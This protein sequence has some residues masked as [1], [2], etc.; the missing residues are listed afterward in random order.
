MHHTLSTSSIE[1][2]PVPM[3]NRNIDVD[4]PPPPYTPGKIQGKSE[5]S[6]SPHSIMGD[7]PD[8]DRPQRIVM[9]KFDLYE[10]KTC[11]YV[12]GS[13]Q[14]DTGFRVLRIDRTSPAEPV[15]SADEPVY[16][17]QE[18]IE[19]LK[20]IEH[21]NVSSGKL[22]F[23]SIFGVIGFIKFTE[24]YY[25]YLITKRSVVALIGGHYVYHIDDTKLLPIGQP[26]KHGKNSDEMRYTGI[27]HN[28]DL[29]K[30]FYFSYTYDITNTLQRNM[31][32]PP[33]A[34]DDTGG[35]VG[36]TYNGMF[37]W[38]HYLLENG[39]KDLTGKSDWILPIIYGFVDQAKISVFGRNVFVTLIARRS[40][41]FA[42]ARFL[43]RGV[44]DKGYVANDVELEQIVAEMSTTSFHTPDRLFGNP[45][46]TSHVQHRGSIPLFWSQ[47]SQ[48]NSG[49][50]PKPPITLNVVDPFYTAAG[51]HFDD[52]FKR[53][54]APCIILNL[55]KQ[56][57]K[58]P[59]ESILLGEFSAAINY[60][61]QFLPEEK[62][63]QHIA[64][65]MSRASKSPDQDV[66]G[67]LEKIAEKSLA[68]T[69]FFHSGPEPYVNVMRR[70]QA[71]KDEK[72][73][74][75]IIARQN[76]VVRTN[77]IDCLDR[78]NA[79]QF[80]VGKCALGQQLYALGIIDHPN[81]EFDS[82]VVNILTEMYHDHGDTIALQYGGSHL[83][84]TME[85]YRKINQW[86]SHSR[87]MIESIRRYINNSFG[88]PEKQEAINLFL[89]NYVVNDNQLSLWDLTTDHFLHNQRLKAR[90]N[91]QNWWTADAIVR[92]EEKEPD[93]SVFT[94]SLHQPHGLYDEADLYTG[95][96]A[97]YYRPRQHTSFEEMFAYNMNGTMKYWPQRITDLSQ[98]SPFV[99]RANGALSQTENASIVKKQER[100]D[101]DKTYKSK[102]KPPAGTIE[103]MV[104]RSLEPSVTTSETKEYRRYINQ[105]R[106]VSLTS[107]PSN[108]DQ[109]LSNITTHP[110]YQ[111]YAAYVNRNGPDATHIKVQS[112]DEQVY[113]TYVE[114]PKRAASSI[115]GTR[116]N[117]YGPNSGAARGRY[118]AYGS[119]LRTGKFAMPSSS[120]AGNAGLI[121]TG[122]ARSPP[123][124]SGSKRWS[125]APAVGGRREG[126]WDDAR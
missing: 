69:G 43:K 95:Y 51:L 104:V 49:M 13:N 88:D 114:M 96:W 12:V 92:F 58:T 94:I 27:F 122:E 76:G 33:P 16:T 44:N 106:N 119:Y 101:D 62:K 17:K 68:D 15:I 24:G 91:Y 36:S 18:V 63:I 67:Y 38:N 6:S 4:T 112:I 21:E 41:H 65:D 75:R 8:G 39:F 83:V 108:V 7:L 45:R 120:S 1:T 9:I 29:T 77:C 110:E 52:M 123:S 53:Y 61:N 31:T 19:L 34:T 5:K 35:G 113:A 60:L 105:F 85:T 57:E 20:R 73:E 125:N 56:K 66:I 100:E 89:G 28:V 117:V 64:W 71:M 55:I 10:T 124:G 111:N 48:D 90:R 79:A 3:P 59:R 87:D 93:P 22:T 126:Q 99:V 23:I 78:T 14:S 80:V 84:N 103:G 74:R 102:D 54:G 81:V 116:E 86:T 118:D 30:N 98:L 109:T 97:E 40:R 46:Y 115:Q 26:T 47:W 32:R 50:S 2:L 70:E 37:V 107:T 42:G 11:Y 82:D 121:G 72:V 25:I